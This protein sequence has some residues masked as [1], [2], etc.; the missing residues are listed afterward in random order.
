MEKSNVCTYI[1]FINYP[2]GWVRFYV[3][4]SVNFQDIFAR[5]GPTFLA[6]VAKNIGN[7]K[8][9]FKCTSKICP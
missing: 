3:R 6:K 4:H 2:F 9:V 1:S 7:L 5:K 8:Q